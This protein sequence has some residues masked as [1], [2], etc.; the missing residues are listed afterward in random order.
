[1]RWKTSVG[2]YYHRKEEGLFSPSQASN[3]ECPISKISLQP[4]WPSLVTVPYLAMVG[5]FLALEHSQERRVWEARDLGQEVRRWVI[6]VSQSWPLLYF[7]LGVQSLAW[8]ALQKGELTYITEGG[9]ETSPFFHGQLEPRVLHVQ[10]WV[11]WWH[12]CWPCRTSFCI[13]NLLD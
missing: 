8:G 1:M 6:L 10:L 13:K 2:A 11:A 3:G 7:Y 12:V 4:R 9:M 5:I